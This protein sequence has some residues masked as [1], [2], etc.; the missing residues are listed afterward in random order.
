MVQIPAGIHSLASWHCVSRAHAP[1]HKLCGKL[2]SLPGGHHSVDLWMMS[3]SVL[4]FGCGRS[5]N[6]VVPDWIHLIL[7]G[8]LP[9]QANHT[10]GY[11]HVFLLKQIRVNRNPGGQN[12]ST[13]DGKSLALRP[14]CLMK[15]HLPKSRLSPSQHFMSLSNVH[16]PA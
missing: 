14:E 6:F 13:C 15:H 7:Q 12:A 11:L 3:S 16:V 8:N 10:L 5:L 4:Q 9:F 2:T 1:S